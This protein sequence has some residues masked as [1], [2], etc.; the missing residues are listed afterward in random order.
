MEGRLAGA[1]TAT[2]ATTNIRRICDTPGERQHLD[3]VFV[4]VVG[5]FPF[6]VPN[7]RKDV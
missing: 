4:L 6:D 1:A 7:L 3:F 5:G 2:T